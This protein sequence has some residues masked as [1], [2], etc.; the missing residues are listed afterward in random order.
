MNAVTTGGRPSSSLHFAVGEI[1]GKLDQLLVTFI[2]EIAQLKQADDA[3][4]SRV[5]IV[6]LKLSRFAGGGLVVLFLIGSWE[7]VRYVLIPH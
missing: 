1:S 4:D 3:L 5:S 6:E 2:P 7:F